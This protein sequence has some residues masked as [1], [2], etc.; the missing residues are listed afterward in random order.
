[1]KIFLHLLCDLVIAHQTL[2]G[3]GQGAVGAVHST[4]LWLVG[5]DRRTNSST[6]SNQ[7]RIQGTGV[8]ILERYMDNHLYLSL[9]QS[10][11]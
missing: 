6:F 9:P 5:E 1:M 4:L 3:R 2:G 10:S 8:L 11:Q 7:T